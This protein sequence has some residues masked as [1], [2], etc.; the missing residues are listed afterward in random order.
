MTLH[1]VMFTPQ[2]EFVWVTDRLAALG[3]NNSGT[4]E[5]MTHLRDQKIACS[6][7]GDWVSMWTLMIRR[8]CQWYSFQT[9]RLD[10]FRHRGKFG[11][12]VDAGV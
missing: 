4:V 7:W 12:D 9:Y 3:N 8:S 2:H 10:L 11:I 1:V 5:K 6:I